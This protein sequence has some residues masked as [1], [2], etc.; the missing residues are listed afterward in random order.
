MRLVRTFEHA[1]HQD[2]GTWGWKLAG[3]NK[4]DPL[5]GMAVAHDTLEHFPGDDAT[6]IEGEFKALG[7]A[8]WIRG[9]GQY[10]ARHSAMNP[11][12]GSHILADIE[13]IWGLYDSGDATFRKAPR[14]VPLTEEP[15]V[16]IAFAVKRAT[17]QLAHNAD[18]DED[19]AARREF[20]QDSVGWLR[21]GYRAAKRRYAGLQA[22]WV[23]DMFHEIEV[24][25]DK[26]LRDAT[27][28]AG[29]TFVVS[30]A[31]RRVDVRTELVEPALV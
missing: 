13:T 26:A 3:D 24:A 11:R 30:C 25:A 17:E 9:D 29:C 5:A 20:V 15:E 10:W 28:G 18:H 27:E 22:Y 8:L 4:M 21:I 23:C 31:V 12:A 14:T 7:A 19:E 16:E 2:Y 6:T 1:Q